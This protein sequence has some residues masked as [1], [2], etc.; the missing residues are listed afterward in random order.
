V[1]P[2]APITRPDLMG[3]TVDCGRMAKV[4]GAGDGRLLGDPYV[5]RH[6]GILTYIARGVKVILI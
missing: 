1:L 6:M 5:H 2:A 3:E 4:V